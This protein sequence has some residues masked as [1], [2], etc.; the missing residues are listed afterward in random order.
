MNNM[1]T[2]LLIFALNALVGCQYLGLE[3]TQVGT[4]LYYTEQWKLAQEHLQ[5][6]NHTEAER[7]FKEIYNANLAQDPEISTRAL[8]E[9]AL[10]NEG[11][12]QWDLALAQF[13]E[14]EARKQF[15][16]LLKGELEL[17]A[18]LSGLYATLG[19]IQMSDFYSKKAESALQTYSAQIRLDLQPS[20]WAETFY[21][22][23]YFPIAEMNED[24]WMNFAYRFESTCQYLIRSMELSDVIWSQRSYDLATTFLKKS[25]GQLNV[26]Q[27]QLE[28]NWVIKAT[29]MQDKMNQLG[30]IIEKM[31]IWEPIDP[32]KS[33]HIKSFYEALALSEKELQSRLVSFRPYTPPSP[34]NLRRNAIKREGLK[35]SPVPGDIDKTKIDPNL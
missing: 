30:G 28:E 22:M 20:W 25:L 11:R 9:L 13:R 18:R 6:Q 32:N 8:F 2:L 5:E 15:L 17:P 12:G 26:D 7:I 19:E 3:R 10:I 29:A 33:Q 35:I 31:K 1:T 4:G 23:G 24:N 14:C 16:P 27:N 21:K 34:D